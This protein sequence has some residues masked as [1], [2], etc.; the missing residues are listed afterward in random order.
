MMISAVR[1]GFAR[2]WYSCMERCS[3]PSTAVKG[4][5]TVAHHPPL[6]AWE[7]TVRLNKDERKIVRR[8]LQDLA[9][10]QPVGRGLADEVIYVAH[11]PARIPPLKVCIEG[12]IGRCRV[13]PAQHEG[14]VDKRRPAPAR[15]PSAASQG[16]MWTIFSEIIASNG[17]FASTPHASLRTSMATGARTL[18]SPSVAIHAL[19]LAREAASGSLGSQTSSG[20]A[21]AKQMAC[22][23]VPDPISSTMPFFG[24]TRV[25][26]S[27]IGPQLRAAD[28][29][30]CRALLTP[31]RSSTARRTRGMVGVRHNRW[32]V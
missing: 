1:W 30:N 29:E 18:A 26:T 10:F 19:M 8:H 16:A 14:P 27:R 12:S 28:G 5:G 15:S 11:A 7:G 21:V 2:L 22:S 13:C 3:C 25:S 20:S 24:R 23:P 9:Q 32:T 4:P 17:A 31:L 6:L